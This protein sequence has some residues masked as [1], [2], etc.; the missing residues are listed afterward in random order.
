MAIDLGHE[1][2]VGERERL[3][4]LGLEARRWVAPALLGAALA[5]LFLVALRGHIL[6]MRYRLDA[7]YRLESQLAKD[8]AVIAARYW[9]LRDPTRLGESARRG[10]TIPECVVHVGPDGSRLPGG[11]AP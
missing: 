4:T 5:G 1:W 8:H 9:R 7:D 11:C 10:F 6:Q 2:I 3:R